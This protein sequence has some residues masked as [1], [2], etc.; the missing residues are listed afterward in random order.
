MITSQTGLMGLIAGLLSIPMGLAL[1]AGLI[2]VVNRRSF[3]W[4]M[5][6]QIFP[7][8]LMEAVALAVVA[9][10]LAGIYP[11]IR[12]AMSSPAEALREE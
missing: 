6:L 10:L 9:A 4:S 5:D 1:A 11:A 7:I 8:V 2:F 3:G 12:M